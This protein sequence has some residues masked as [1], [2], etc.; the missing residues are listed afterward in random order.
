MDNYLGQI[1]LFAGKKT[2][3]DWAE[4]DGRLFKIKDHQAL[5]NIIGTAN[6]TDGENSFALPKIEAPMHT[7]RYIICTKG[8]VPDT[9][10]EN[11]LLNIQTEK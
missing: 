1:I 7:M 3:V 2:P 8:F 4:C 11:N 6:A 10:E 5:F 9:S